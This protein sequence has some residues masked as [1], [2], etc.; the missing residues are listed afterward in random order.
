MELVKILSKIINEN[1]NIQ[2]ILLEYPES[3][4]KRLVDKFSLETG[5]EINKTDTEDIFSTSASISE[6]ET[7]R[8]I[9]ER[10]NTQNFS[11]KQKKQIMEK[12]KKKFY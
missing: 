4:I 8:K 2:K 6:E 11:E 10:L 1:L 7:I 12:V 5:E 9:E 3:T